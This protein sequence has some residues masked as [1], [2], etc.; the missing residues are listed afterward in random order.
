MPSDLCLLSMTYVGITSGL[1]SMT[2]VG[3]TSDL[4]SMTYVGITS[5]FENIVVETNA[6]GLKDSN[7][8]TDLFRQIIGCLRD[9]WVHICTHVHVF[10]PFCF[11]WPQGCKTFSM[12]NS[13]EHEIFPAHKCLNAK[14]YWH[15]NIYKQENNIYLSLKRLN[16]FIFILVSI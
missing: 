11:T 14:N 9:T 4:L 8:L 16:F 10:L 12:L 3:I 15:F 2:Y 7:N 13:A 5:G 1:L 6:G